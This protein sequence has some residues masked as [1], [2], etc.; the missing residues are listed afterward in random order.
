MSDLNVF[1]A[2]DHHDAM[3]GVWPVLRPMLIALTGTML[4]G[5]IVVPYAD[6]GYP[7]WEGK[8]DVLVR[9]FAD[10]AYCQSLIL[11]GIFGLLYAAIQ[12]LTVY[13][14]FRIFRKNLQEPGAHARVSGRWLALVGRKETRILQLLKEIPIGL[15]STVVDCATEN[16]DAGGDKKETPSDEKGPKSGAEWTASRVDQY[17]DQLIE[18]RVTRL[19]DALLPLDS[20]I[21]ALPLLGF[22]GTVIGITGSI[23]GLQP[24][25]EGIAAGTGAS[26]NIGQVLGQLSFAFDTTLVGLILVLP[27][28]F[29]A[30]FVRLKSYALDHDI[31]A[32]TMRT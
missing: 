16:A 10:N 9:V 27:I 23:A 12:F 13:A 11:V 28:Y 30:M 20:L 26:G 6:P 29:A 7:F 14:E 25:L 22:I 8:A 19:R 3:S 4:L 24:V 18:L 21:W 5:G 31:R 1:K 2:K 15:A 32:N 17:V